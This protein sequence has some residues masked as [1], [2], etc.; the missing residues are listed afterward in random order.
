M[1]I[2]AVDTPDITDDAATEQSGKPQ[3]HWIAVLEALE[4]R[5]EGA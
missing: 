2:E 4:H 1:N 3:A 5:Q